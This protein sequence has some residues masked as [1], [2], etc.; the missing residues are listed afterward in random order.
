[1][2][3]VITAKR[4]EGRLGA[5]PYSTS[6]TSGVS[7][8]SSSSGTGSGQGIQFNRDFGQHILKNPLVLNA[9]VDKANIRPSDVVL[10]V[11]P[12]TGNLT[13]R[14]LEKASRVIACEIDPRLIAELQKR[15][16]GSPLAS[17]LHIIQ[18]DVLKADLPYF[19]VCV[20][21]LPYQISSP[22]VFKLLLHRPL[23]RSAV[24]MFQR[25]FA[26]R[27]VAQ[28]SDKLYCR[29]SINTQ[30]LSKVEHLMKI[31]KNNFRPPPK[32][33]SSVVRIEPKNPPPAI[34]YK[35]WDGLVRIAFVRKNKTLS[36]G[37]KTTS[38]MEMLD[39]NYRTH[40]SLT[41]TVI[42]PDL[43]IKKKVEAI[44]EKY[45]FGKMRARTMDLD[46]FLKL[47]HVMNTEGIHFA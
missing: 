29:L 45:D 28:P 40:C 47:L 21:N 46:E 1:M 11:G 17:K 35:E 9:I 4:K 24:L 39:K 5:K 3:K 23:F 7:N 2:P 34:N 32:V 22:F 19:D 38:M 6:S 15:V 16:Q 41:N 12:G 33:E 14:L 10:E 8:D 43:D 44:L 42:E 37:F 36:A 31:G 30:L 27:L 25:E 20:A 13:V 18:G 26:Q